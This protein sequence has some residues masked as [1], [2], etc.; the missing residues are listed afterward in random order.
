[1]SDAALRTFDVKLSTGITIHVAEAGPADASPVILLHGFPESH[2]T[3]RAVAP[4][5]SDRLRLVMPDMR[6]FGQSDRPTDV[7]AYAT[8]TLIADIFALADALGL[9]RFSLV[10]HDWRGAIAWA[11]AL[12]ADSRITRLAIVNSPHPWIFQRSLIEHADQRAA[13]QYITAFR[14]PAMEARIAAM[15][16]DTF[17]NKSFAKHVD[18][19]RIPPE[20][21]A[22]SIAE[23]SRS[24]ALTAMFNW[25]R[26]SH[27]RVP[28][29][30]EDAPLPGWVERAAPKIHIPVR[31]I[32]GL[33]DQALLPVQLDGIGE[34]GDDVDVV[35]L[36]GVGHFAPWEAPRMVAA[37]L[38]PFLEA[39]RAATGSPS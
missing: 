1:V 37:A 25:Y 12:R 11:A 32:W 6:G 38:G 34:V 3:W 27:I 24:G 18:L 35:P 7:A 22:H 30:G 26:A 33:D 16:F 31:V 28:A 15:G 10:G 9:D 2:R 39:A 36:K 5:L 17:F 29:P 8:D 20:E 14:D 4:L 19:A 13:S 23:W 21:R